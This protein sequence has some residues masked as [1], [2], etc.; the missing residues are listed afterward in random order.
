MKSEEI[1]AGAV[2]FMPFKGCGF[3]LDGS[4]TG[5]VGMDDTKIPPLQKP[6]GWGTRRTFH[7]GC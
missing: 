6:Q 4:D 5:N 1:S 3:S 2:P 7:N